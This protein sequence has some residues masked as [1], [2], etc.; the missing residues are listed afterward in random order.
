MR[1]V[2]HKEGLNKFQ[3]LIQLRRS[4]AQ[5]L[6]A[7]QILFAL[8]PLADYN[9]TGSNERKKEENEEEGDTERLKGEE[10]N[11]DDGS[12]SLIKLPESKYSSIK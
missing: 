12:A 6:R 9:V 5:T 2:Y 3:L 7:E 8:L 10:I 1:T 4:V 11:A